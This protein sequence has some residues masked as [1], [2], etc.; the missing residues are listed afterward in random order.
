MK[1]NVKLSSVV[2]EYAYKQREYDGRWMLLGKIA[3]IENTYRYKNE[4]NKSVAVIPTIWVI[5]KVYD[6][7]LEV[8]K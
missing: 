1:D 4:Y 7:E 8:E 3:D 2:F 5:I 6:Y